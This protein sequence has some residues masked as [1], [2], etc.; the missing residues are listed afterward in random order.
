MS[1]NGKVTFTAKKDKATKHKDRY[2]LFDSLGNNIGAV[3]WPKDRP[4]PATATIKKGE[5]V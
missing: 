4:F 3:Y 1:E 5:A 2:V